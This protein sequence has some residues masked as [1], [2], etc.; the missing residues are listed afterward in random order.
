[1]AGRASTAVEAAYIAGP[2]RYHAFAWA[3]DKTV[4]VPGTYVIGA[5]ARITR[6]PA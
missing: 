5:I 2:P 6:R 4:R 1:M 3:D